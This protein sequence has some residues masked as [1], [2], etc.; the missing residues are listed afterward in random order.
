M[1]EPLFSISVKIWIHAYCESLSLIPKVNTI[2]RKK[3]LS[4]RQIPNGNPLITF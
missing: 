2:L 3:E 1:K 4:K